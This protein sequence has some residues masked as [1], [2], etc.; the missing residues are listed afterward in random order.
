MDKSRLRL[1]CS[2]IGVTLLLMPLASY[3]MNRGLELLVRLEAAGGW[4]WPPLAWQ[5]LAVGVNALYILIPLCFLLKMAGVPARRLLPLSLPRA[6]YMIPAVGVSF[7]VSLGG[8]L[9]SS[10]ALGLLAGLGFQAQVAMPVFQGGPAA[11]FLTMLLAAVFPALLE[12]LLF[13][14]AILQYLRPY[15]SGFAVLVSGVLFALCHSSAAQFFPALVMGLCLGCFAVRSGSL[16]PGMIFHFAY[17]SAV[18]GLYLVQLRQGMEAYTTMTFIFFGISA[19][20]AAVSA[21][22][23]G[24]RFGPVFALPSAGCPLSREDK[25]AAVF[26]SVPL[27]SAGVIFLCFIAASLTWVGVPG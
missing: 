20:V 6:D 15:G 5:G 16:L 4:G 8:N 26:T 27:L 23:L 19:A 11:V 12:E 25:A 13:R 2:I 10:L 24:R 22:F 21:V 7:G 9:L 1:R 18:I 3:L 14:G 17:N